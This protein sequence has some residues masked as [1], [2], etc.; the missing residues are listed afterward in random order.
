MSKRLLVGIIDYGF[1]NHRSIENSIRKLG[2]LSILSHYKS[3]LDQSDILILPGVGSFHKAMNELHHHGLIKFI[4]QWALQAKP[5]VGIC[6]GMQLFANSGIEGGH[7]IGLG[8]VPGE[9]I[10]L[11]NP[12]NHI[13][14]NELKLKRQDEL[15]TNLDSVDYYFN[16]SY[17]F[18]AK[19]DC[20]IAMANYGIE[21][22][23]I[24]R[25]GT[26]IGLQFHLEKSQSAGL[27]LLKDIIDGL[28]HG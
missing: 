18:N 24:V 22:P 16:H 13:G 17:V 11:E 25:N 3:D 7:T 19:N 6:L 20:V 1:G 15:F 23:A 28:C 27:G 26:V 21:I 10:A 14:W 9:V 5:L 2:H 4:E 8:L 12:M